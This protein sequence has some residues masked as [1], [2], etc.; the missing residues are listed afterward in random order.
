LDP[1][2][3]EGRWALPAA[4]VPLANGN[5]MTYEPDAT[6]YRAGDPAEYWYHVVT[7]AV[8][9][10]VVAGGGRRQ[11]VEFHLPGDTFGFDAADGVHTLI[12][13]AAADRHTTISRQRRADVDGLV[14]G[15]PSM[16][17]RQRE[18]AARL[19]VRA[20]RRMLMLGRQ[21]AEERVAAFLLEMHDRLPRRGE[22]APIAYRLPM[23]RQDI[24]DYLGVTA[25]TLSR[26]LHA[27]RRRGLIALPSVRQ[28]RILDRAAL[29]ALRTSSA[30]PDGDGCAQR[31]SCAPADA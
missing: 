17:L 7:G 19:L 23:G 3:G 24:A 16:A 18:Q 30:E 4:G 26:V 13:Q 15:D 14:R 20:Y 29:A 9:V 25:P 28:V 12:V 21:D 22:A 8:R 11:I 1:R 31:L 5:L 27:L 10:C 2:L 6:I